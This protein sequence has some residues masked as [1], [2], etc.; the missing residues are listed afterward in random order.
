MANSFPLL[1]LPRLALIPVFQQM[2]P[3]DVIAFSLLSNRARFMLKSHGLTVTSINIMTVNHSLVLDIVLGDNKR[4]RLFLRLIPE[5]LSD[6]IGV[7]VDNKIVK[8]RNLGLSRAECIQRIMNVTN[9]A[10]IQELK[11][12]GAESF[13]A[14]PILATLPHIEQIFILENCNEGFVHKMFEMLSKLISNVEIFK[15]Q[16][17]NLEE[18]QKVLM[19]NMN[20]ITINVMTPRDPT[21]L[22]CCASRSLWCHDQCERSQPLF[23]IVDKKQV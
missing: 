23:Q 9:C 6:F 1:R 22:Q 19:L 2:E 12:C 5:N 16:F 7:L 17:E 8:W 14:L 4:L 18:F 10:S 13:D 20:S 21:R 3:I 11:F 15:N